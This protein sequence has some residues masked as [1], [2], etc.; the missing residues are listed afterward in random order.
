MQNQNPNFSSF[1][2]SNSQF[3][4]KAIR[5]TNQV[6]VFSKTDYLEINITKKVKDPTIKIMKH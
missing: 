2:Y 6:T 5:R 4:E 1:Q 3:P